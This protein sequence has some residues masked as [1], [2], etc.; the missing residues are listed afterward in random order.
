MPWLD[1]CRAVEAIFREFGFLEHYRVP[2]E[3]FRRFVLTVRRNYRQVLYHNWDHA[4]EVTQTCYALMKSHTAKLAGTLRRHELFGMLVA[5][6][7]HDI[8]HRGVNNS[9]LRTAEGELWS[10]YGDSSI[11]EKHHFS[12]FVTLVS[13]D[14]LNI[15]QGLTSQEAYKNMLDHIKA[16]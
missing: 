10:L 5:V 6:L 2:V 3:V 8:D 13:C 12:H 11:L 16:C 9:F 7:V 15:F 14:T 1:Q 4:F